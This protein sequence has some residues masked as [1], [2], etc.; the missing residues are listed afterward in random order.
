MTFYRL[1][2]NFLNEREVQVSCVMVV[3]SSENDCTCTVKGDKTET[4][5]AAG[6]GKHFKTSPGYVRYDESVIRAAQLFF[7]TKK[8]MQ[9][10]K[11]VLCRS[12]VQSRETEA[13]GLGETPLSYNDSQYYTQEDGTIPHKDEISLSLMEYTFNR[14]GELTQNIDNIG[15]Y[16][17]CIGSK[18]KKLFDAFKRRE[19]YDIMINGVKVQ[20]NLAQIRWTMF[21]CKYGLFDFLTQNIE[22]VKKSFEEAR[23]RDRNIKRKRKRS[24]NPGSGTTAK[25]DSIQPFSGY[26]RKG[27]RRREKAPCVGAANT[28]M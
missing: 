27:R 10:L 4:R 9:H 11:H 5:F 21:A 7:K 15:I 14:F 17:S 19:S 26:V 28:L 18:G 2:T 8:R 24:R 3:F 25:I 6:Y 13:G 20:T 22:E 16:S 1:G 12:R 23:A